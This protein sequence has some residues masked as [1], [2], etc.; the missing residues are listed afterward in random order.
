M[1]RRLAYILFFLFLSGSLLYAQ[2]A[3]R[4]NIVFILGD[5][6]TNWDIGC[7]GSV[8]SKTPNI[9]K[10]AKEGMKFNKCYQSAPMCSPTR[11]NIFTGLYPVK[12]G[13]YPNHTFVKEGVSSMPHYLKSLGYTVGFTGK[14]HISP[15]AAFPFDY[16][17]KSNNPEFE[18]VDSFLQG[19]KQSGKNFALMIC[20]NEAHDPWTKGD[21][22]VF[23]PDSIRLPPNMIDTY[24]TREAFARYLAE[25]SELDS[26]VGIT[27]SLLEKH[28]F[29]DNT[30]VFFAS[31]QGNIF[32]FNKWSLYEAGVKSALIARMPGMIDAGSETDAI[33]EYTDILP[34]FIEIAGGNIPGNL[35]GYSFLPILQDPTRRIR[36]YSY[37]IHTT[38]GILNGSDHY[39]IRA[40]VND[41]YRFIWNLTPEEEFLN[42][43]NNTK[44]AASSAWDIKWFRSWLHSAESDAAAAALLARN[45]IRPREELYD[46]IEDKWCMNNLAENK[47][48][49]FIKKILKGELMEW[50]RS[51]G[52]KGE[53]TELDAFLHQVRK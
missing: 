13:A 47:N 5:D 37:S 16:I 40:I 12:S 14:K 9:D 22:D 7:Y 3:A 21:K 28:G 2:N 6:I 44:D 41:R 19:A 29:S 33:V 25:I 43:V 4:Y 17:G 8:D 30:F 49:S 31:E 26:Q 20:S 46:I 45:R 15:I 48:Y 39:G 53:A 36:D 24:E 27:M 35:D 34:T 23:S 51:C 18:L 38:R 10:L 52:D 32:P 42:I 1:Y 50:M 11:H